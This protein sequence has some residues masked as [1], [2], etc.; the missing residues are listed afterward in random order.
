[1]VAWRIVEF[2]WSCTTCCFSVPNINAPTSL[3]GRN[4]VPPWHPRLFIGQLHLKQYSD[5]YSPQCPNIY[6]ACCYSGIWRQRTPKVHFVDHLPSDAASLVFSAYA[7][8]SHGQS[9]CCIREPKADRNMEESS[10]VRSAIGS[11]RKG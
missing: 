10:M 4:L 8:L 6:G 1:M 11:Q 3:V 7:H 2:V 9:H 5:R